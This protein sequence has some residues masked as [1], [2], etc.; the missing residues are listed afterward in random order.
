[1]TPKENKSNKNKWSISYFMATLWFIAFCF[2][3]AFK[4][5]LFILY[6]LFWPFVA[7][8]LIANVYLWHK[9]FKTQNWEKIQLT[10]IESGIEKG[11]STKFLDDRISY[12]YIYRSQHF[13]GKRIQY[14]FMYCKE[15]LKSD[16][17][18]AIC[19]N[20]IRHVFVNPKNPSE[21]TIIQGF[22]RGDVAF[23]LQQILFFWFMGFCYHVVSTSA[24]LPQ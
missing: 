22:D 11:L 21:S 3:A 12:S 13:T 10:D 7:W 6:I 1:M 16:L 19:A 24:V 9:A 15:Q 20:K 23:L 17:W 4:L 18:E 2:V 5:P 8:A 14:P